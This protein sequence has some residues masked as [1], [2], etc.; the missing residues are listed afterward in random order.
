MLETE[1][2][3]SMNLNYERIKLDGKPEERRYQY[4]ILSRG[5]I[6]GLLD[7]SL[8]FI[9]GDAFLYYDITSKQS[10]SKMFYNKKTVDRE[11]VKDLCGIR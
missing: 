6:R 4:C 3:K 10:I 2:L 1:Y 8:R 7:C 5:G 9:N 11:W